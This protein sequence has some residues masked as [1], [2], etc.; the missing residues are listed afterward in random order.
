MGG[1]CEGRRGESKEGAFGGMSTI[2]HVCTGWEEGEVYR[3]PV[4]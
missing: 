4:R 2:N 3:L 1:G